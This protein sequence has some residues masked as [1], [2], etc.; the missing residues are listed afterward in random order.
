MIHKDVIIGKIVEFINNK[1]SIIYG[2]NPLILFIKPL[3]DRVINNN[4][5]KLDSILKLIQDDKGMI[6]IENILTEM[7]N[8]LLVAAKKDYPD[9]LGGISIGDGKFVLN[10]PGI[11]KGIAFT[12]DDIEDLKRLIVNK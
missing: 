4:I 9:I 3:F 12:S 5:G 10:I 7:V 11:N 8:N 1:L 6:D 2:N